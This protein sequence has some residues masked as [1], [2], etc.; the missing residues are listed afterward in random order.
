[1]NVTGMSK[2]SPKAKPTAEAI[3]RQCERH[4]IGC[5]FG[6]T[7]KHPYAEITVNRQTR[8]VYFASTPSDYR[9]W[10]NVISD[11]KKTAR[12][13]GWEPN[14]PINEETD[15]Q[16][17]KSLSD[18]PRLNDPPAPQLPLEFRGKPV[19]G[20]ITAPELVEAYAKRNKWILDRHNDGM[21]N[22][23]IWSQLR[24]AG[25]DIATPGAIEMV[26]FKSKGGVYPSQVKRGDVPPPVKVEKAEKV[27]KAAPVEAPPEI[28][29]GLDPLIMAIAH[30]IAPLI[31][32]QLAQQGKQLEAYKAKADKWDAIAGLV[33]DDA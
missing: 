33:R 2:I 32:A 20:R 27:E 15:M 3:A 1:M 18:L 11:V 7:G 30:V 12:L 5:K 14:A 28:V 24:D 16:T 9:G 17:V 4:G 6:Q 23:Q 26:V 21:R 10:M 25:W 13:L 8:K 19:R 31:R 22:M 29:E